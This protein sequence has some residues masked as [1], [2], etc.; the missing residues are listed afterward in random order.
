MYSKI[1]LQCKNGFL[2]C[3]GLFLLARVIM[4]TLH[5]LEFRLSI[6]T[7]KLLV[8][9]RLSVPMFILRFSI[10]GQLLRVDLCTFYEINMYMAVL[11]C[12]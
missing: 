3:D 8:L 4:K 7:C 12:N 6:M 5:P 2:S 1:C 10:E 9:N 11:L